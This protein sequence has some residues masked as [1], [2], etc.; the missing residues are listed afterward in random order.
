MDTPSG[1][2][3]EKMK[4]KEM[5]KLEPTIQEKK[6]LKSQREMIEKI[7]QEELIK[8]KIKYRE[9]IKD[10]YCMGIKTKLAAGP[11]PLSVRKKGKNETIKSNPGKIMKEKKRRPRKGVRS[12]KLSVKKLEQA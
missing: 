12:K 7:R 1:T 10:L 4:Y 6:F 8:D 9:S 2:F 11:N 3:H 5:M